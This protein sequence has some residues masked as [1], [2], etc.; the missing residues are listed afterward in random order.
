MS[1]IN[2]NRL[3][4]G[5]LIATA[6]CFLSDGLLH[7]KLLGADW[8]AVFHNLRTATPAEEQTSAMAYFLVFELGRGFVAIL[9]YVLM[10]PFFQPG[11]KTAALAGLVTWFAFS[12]TG[13]AQFI[14][15][16]F[17]SH[18]LWMKAGAFQLV[19]SIVAA[20]AA[21]AVYKDK[22]V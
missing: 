7:E 8:E 3:L 21:A 13:P 10:R 9:V 14:P 17:Y 15:L 11:P 12:L 19:T 5:G 22:T 20:I 16:G 2:W 18:A 1:R 4:I 6:I